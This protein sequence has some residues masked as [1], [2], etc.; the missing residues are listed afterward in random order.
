[1]STVCCHKR[2]GNVQAILTI[3]LLIC[4]ELIT[5]LN[6]QN[7]LRSSQTIFLTD[8]VNW[9]TNKDISSGV[10][11]GPGAVLTIEAGAILKF[12][13]ASAVILVKGVLR[14]LGRPDAPIVFDGTDTNRGGTAIDLEG[15]TGVN[16]SHATFRNFD[17]AVDNHGQSPNGYQADSVYF[18]DCVFEQNALAVSS[19]FSYRVF[20]MRCKFIRSVNIMSAMSGGLFDGCQF[21]D[22]TMYARNG[23]V[24]VNCVFTNN[25]GVAVY[26]SYGASVI[27]CLFLSNNLAMM[28]WE[29]ASV[30]NCLFM[31]NRL[32]VV[33]QGSA[34]RVL[35]CIFLSNSVALYVGGSSSDIRVVGGWMCAQPR[36]NSTDLIQVG[37][38]AR[39]I[40]VVGV[41]FG[42]SGRYEAVIRGSIKDQYWFAT[43]GLVDLVN[44]TEQPTAWPDSLQ[45]YTSLYAS[46]CEA[47]QDRGLDLMNPPSGVTLQPP[48]GAILICVSFL[49]F[50]V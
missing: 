18:E 12:K 27:N 14:V 4:L 45:Q 23:D 6:S 31:W 9:S 13:S 2:A 50:G 20:F 33:A 8:A 38:W 15:A 11:V 10:I 47:P 22:Q 35:Q 7:V 48:N 29:S 32:A 43:S 19:L 17:R 24:F 3:L 5:K 30:S 41:W 34:T 49:A 28:L 25:T 40:E 1:M 37:S 39:S 36:D 21:V 42:I 44:L 16:V 26:A 46:L